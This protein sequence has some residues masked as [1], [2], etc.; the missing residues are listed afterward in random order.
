MLYHG[1]QSPPPTAHIRLH[2]GVNP[3]HDLA[4]CEREGRQPRGRLEHTL[5]VPHVGTQQT[6]SEAQGARACVC[7]VRC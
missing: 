6:V 1:K 7:G 3:R 5:G 4:T 2:R